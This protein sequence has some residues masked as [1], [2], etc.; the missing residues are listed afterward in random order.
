MS[1]EKYHGEG[2]LVYIKDKPSMGLY[3]VVRTFHFFDSRP[4]YEL[5]AVGDPYQKYYT[6]TSNVLTTDEIADA[7]TQKFRIGDAVKIVDIFSRG[8]PVQGTIKKYN[9]STNDDG[10]ETINYLVVGKEGEHSAYWVN[11]NQLNLIARKKKIGASTYKFKAGDSV[12]FNT[13]SHA[14]LNCTGKVQRVKTLETGVTRYVVKAETGKTYLL[15]AADLTLIKDEN[16][17][18]EETPRAKF[19]IGSYVMFRKT[20]EDGYRV[21]QVRSAQKYESLKYGTTYS[22][23]IDGNAIREANL[24]QVPRMPKFKAGD[25]VRHMNTF[26]CWYLVK[27]VRLENFTEWNE[28]YQYRILYE[29]SCCVVPESVLSEIKHECEETI[30]AVENTLRGMLKRSK[31]EAQQEEHLS[32]PPPPKARGCQHTKLKSRRLG[33]GYICLGMLPMANGKPGVFACGAVLEELP[34]DG[35]MRIIDGVADPC[36]GHEARTKSD[37][38]QRTAEAKAA[39]TTM[40]KKRVGVGSMRKTKTYSVRKRRWPKKL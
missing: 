29:G 19:K 31:E 12:T 1:D 34:T 3:S 6:P 14:S 11:A 35:V 27:V 7:S 40:R 2:T 39:W 30:A 32:P 15:P 26:G 13:T 23:L 18:K 17:S 24:T 5:Q 10:T 36:I 16:K 20:L 8:E 28:S 21:G 25:D 4:T 37:S 22:Y 38:K 33:G 9:T